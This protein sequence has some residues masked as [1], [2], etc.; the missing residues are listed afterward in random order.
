MRTLGKRILIGLISAVSLIASAAHAVEEPKYTVTQESGAFQVREYPALVAA[1]VTVG[2][3]RDQASNAGFRLLAGYIFGGNQGRQSIAMTAPVVVQAQGQAIPM[4]APVTQTETAGAWTI[5]FNMPHG[6][7]LA[8]LPRPNDPRVHLIALPPSRVAVVRF[9]GL[10]GT[11][12]IARRTA[13]L[14]AFIDANHLRAAGPPSLARYNP[15]WT[16]GPFRR[17]EIVIPLG[18]G[19]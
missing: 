1:E 11:A 18:A 8:S 10:A 9:S 16:L 13:A 2:G 19:G 6:Y 12:E 15:P 14:T 7:T 4:T 3:T 17:N 5:R